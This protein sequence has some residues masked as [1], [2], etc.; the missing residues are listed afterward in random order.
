MQ[1]LINNWT[2]QGY[3]P[4]VPIS[5]FT[6]E[7]GI[8]FAGCTKEMSINSESIYSVLKRNKLIKNY[9]LDNNTFD[10][11]WVANRWWVYRSNINI[12][13]NNPRLVI[14]GVDGAFR[15]FYNNEFLARHNNSFTRLVIDMKKYNNTTGQLL[16]MVEHLDKTINQVG[17][18][19]QIDVQRP[20][21]DSKWDF[22]PR[23]ISLGI[24]APIYIEYD[25]K[26][27]E[28]K[29][30]QNIKD[31]IG[32]I[33]V[34][35]KGKYFTDKSKVIFNLRFNGEIITQQES[36]LE[37]GNIQ[38]IINNPK[39]Y[40]INGYG[41][42]N[43]YSLEINVINE[44]GIVD[45]NLYNVAF[46][47]VEF[48]KNEVE[49]DGYNYTLVVNGTKRYIKGVNFVPIEMSRA[50]F[51]K[52][53]YYKLLFTAKEMNVNFIRVWGGGIIETEDFYNICDELGILVWQDFIQSSSG[54]D[55]DANITDEF[56]QELSN[57]VIESVKRI[58]N[59]PSLAIYC[60]G[61]ELMD[62]K[63][64]PLDYDNKNIAAIKELVE[65]YD[66]TRYFLPTT[67]SGNM[68]N[69]DINKSG[70]N[71]HDDI[72]GSW[73][74]DGNDFHY[75][76]YNSMD[77]KLHSEF[78][79][80]GSCNKETIN[81]I[82]SAK[83]RKYKLYENS[84]VL[85]Q[86]FVW[87]NRAEWWNNIPSL[88]EIF[89]DVKN[90]NEFVY[91]GQFMQGEALRYA[92][93]SDRR[94]AYVNSGSIIW[95]LNEPFPNINCTNLVD[96]YTNKKLSSYLVRE[97]YDDVVISVKKDKLVYNPGEKLKYEIYLTSEKLPLGDVIIESQLLTKN[98]K[99]E[100]KYEIKSDK[101][102]DEGRTIFV[103]SE[104]IIVPESG[105]IS[106]E[107][108]TDSFGK[109]ISTKILFFIK[110]SVSLAKKEA[111]KYIKSLGK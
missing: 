101:I 36:K 93:E 60:G 88:N 37:S 64:K 102:L 78:G 90:I 105:I 92:I 74:F 7:N 50:D 98:I 63:Y 96:Y 84:N 89:G 69:F 29:I 20:R 15:V 83:N 2:V 18:T 106:L 5:G 19:S 30:T 55:N 111:I 85:D 73:T 8:S 38:L 12:E 67:A 95:Q 35:Y 9:Y 4:N 26:I 17:Y 61:N 27:V 16:I 71:V 97:A 51:T 72:H 58:R 40:E 24:V 10:A 57:T 103:A 56:I 44:L 13:G 1:R 79:C 48:I 45:H 109:T 34:E 110:G 25:E 91:L 33:N 54:I 76:V 47:T 82:L 99:Q 46:R 41:N 49:Y 22:C 28:T 11:E 81:K 80:D 14:E 94:R 62:S 52:E 66:G 104:E 39:I 21:F 75:K 6:K 59:H 77:C 32:I 23:L 70:L 53:K 31:D 107:L 65:K 86:N 87:R 42:Q 3:F 108:K 100:K 43:L 68:A